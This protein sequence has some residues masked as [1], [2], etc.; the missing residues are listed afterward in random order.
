V[1]DHVRRMFGAIAD[2]E[3]KGDETNDI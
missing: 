2:E 1:A 3:T